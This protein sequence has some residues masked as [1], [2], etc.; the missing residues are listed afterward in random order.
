MADRTYRA[1]QVLHEM[2]ATP[3]AT[4]RRRGAILG[5]LSAA[6]LGYLLAVAP[7]AALAFFVVLAMWARF[8]K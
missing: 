5:L 3:R 2:P 6:T 7:W 1:W 4:R 8:A